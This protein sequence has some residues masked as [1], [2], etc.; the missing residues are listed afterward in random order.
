MGGLETRSPEKLNS[1]FFLEMSIYLNRVTV[2][3]IGIGTVI[4]KS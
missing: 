2:D 4:E 1:I 3:K